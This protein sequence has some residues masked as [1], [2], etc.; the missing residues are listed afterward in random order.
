M[1]NT[2]LYFC[3]FRTTD[4]G[5]HRVQQ[6]DMRGWIRIAALGGRMLIVLEGEPPA[7]T[8][9]AGL[10]AGLEAG[11]LTVSMKTLVDLTKYVGVV[12]WTSLK[13]LSELA[14]WGKVGPENSA[15]AY[16]VR[17]NEF[18]M[19][20]KVISALFGRTRHR[21]FASRADAVAWLTQ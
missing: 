19:V 9:T 11:W 5:V 7:D 4:D 6:G 13:K 1:D 15:V 17:N 12:D 21:A 20:I 8:I 18:G 2:A 10:R 3:D 16:V 14:E